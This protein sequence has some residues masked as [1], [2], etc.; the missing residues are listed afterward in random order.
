M[1]LI[2]LV[3]WLLVIISSVMNYLYEWMKGQELDLREYELDCR[4]GYNYEIQELVKQIA[5]SID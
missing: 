5:A 4:I 3:F 1:E 2:T